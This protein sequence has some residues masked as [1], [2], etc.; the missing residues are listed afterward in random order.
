MLWQCWKGVKCDLDWLLTSAA[1]ESVPKGRRL[2]R[3][4]C[5]RSPSRARQVAIASTSKWA[6]EDLLVGFRV[7]AQ[8]HTSKQSCKGLLPFCRSTVIDALE[9]D[10]PP[11]CCR[12][13]TV[14]PGWCQW[15][16]MGVLVLSIV[17]PRH[18]ADSRGARWAGFDASADEPDTWGHDFVPMRN[19]ASGSTS[20]LLQQASQAHA[21]EPHPAVSALR[22]VIAAHLPKSLCSVMVLG[23]ETAALYSSEARLL[24]QRDCRDRF[25][26]CAL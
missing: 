12:S 10:F 19:P 2:Q 16:P 25:V 4:E 6:L 15:L 13:G 22:A 26:Q 14:M 5:S 17:E 9:R 3:D 20:A 21:A 23:L 18:L 7:L 24:W 8:P 11:N 1:C